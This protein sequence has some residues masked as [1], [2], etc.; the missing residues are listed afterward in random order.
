MVDEDGF[1]GRLRLQLDRVLN[2]VCFHELLAWVTPFGVC[3]SSLSCDS[4][5]SCLWGRATVVPSIKG[6]KLPL[7]LLGSPQRGQYVEKA[8]DRGFLGL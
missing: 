8:L 7:M 1:W 4:E 2:L 6:L 5:D 3:G